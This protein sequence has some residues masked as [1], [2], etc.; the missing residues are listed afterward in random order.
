[1]EQVERNLQDA[2]G[3]AR[4]V[5]FDPRLVPGGGAVEMAVSRG[6]HANADSIQVAYIY[7]TINMH[8]N[9][10][11]KKNDK[12][13]ATCSHVQHRN[14]RPDLPDAGWMQQHEEEVEILWRCCMHMGPDVVWY[15]R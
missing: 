6:L 3:V 2:M 13:K 8:K 4:N 5:C 11:V 12:N 10:I 15:L 1:M 9:K 14:K 7:M